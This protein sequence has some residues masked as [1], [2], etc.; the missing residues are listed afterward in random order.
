MCHIDSNRKAIDFRG[1]TD[2]RIS[3]RWIQNQAHRT[4]SVQVFVREADISSR[5]ACNNPSFFGEMKTATFGKR[6]ASFL[7]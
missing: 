6:F 3:Q 4:H 2:S 5:M 7:L 1:Q